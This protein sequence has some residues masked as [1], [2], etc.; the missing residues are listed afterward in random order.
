LESALVL[1]LGINP[2]WIRKVPNLGRRGSAERKRFDG[3]PDNTRWGHCEEKGKNRK[4][5]GGQWSPCGGDKKATAIGKS[6]GGSDRRKG[7]PSSAYRMV[8]GGG[9]CESL[10]RWEGEAWAGGPKI[11]VPFKGG[12]ARK[13]ATYYVERGWGGGFE[14]GHAKQHRSEVLLRL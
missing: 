1:G 3:E 11:K 6:G 10:F 8:L 13:G 7:R 12:L 4:G 5:G 14:I 9:N 2:T